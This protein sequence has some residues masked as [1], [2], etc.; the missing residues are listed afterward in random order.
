MSD[1][2]R[3][4][5][6]F[7]NEILNNDCSVLHHIHLILQMKLFSRHTLIA[8]LM[9]LIFTATSILSTTYAISIENENP[10]FSVLSQKDSISCSWI[11]AFTFEEKDLNE[12]NLEQLSKKVK[13]KHLPQIFFTTIN[14]KFGMPRK[15]ET[16][17][18][19]HTY[20]VKPL[21]FSFSSRFS[22][23]EITF[24]FVDY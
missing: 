13:L 10:D 20:W 17:C 6:Y 2:I 1:S 4:I 3:P 14:L 11:L 22:A 12:D 16:P 15:E 9:L 7:V 18:L 24:W 19:P 23:C 8:F 5:N 21:Q